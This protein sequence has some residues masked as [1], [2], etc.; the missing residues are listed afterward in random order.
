MSN[1]NPFSF[2]CLARQ[3]GMLCFSIIVT[4]H[5][6]FAKN[7]AADK[8]ENPLPIITAFFKFLNLT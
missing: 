5:P 6:Y 2:N 4:S 3:P 8:P 7:V 1:V